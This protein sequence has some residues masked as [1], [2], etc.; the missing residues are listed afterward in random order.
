LATA[1]RRNL[2]VVVPVTLLGIGGL[3][4]TY[5]FSGSLERALLFTLDLME[6]ETLSC[7]L[8]GLL[9]VLTGGVLPYLTETFESRL[10]AV[11]GV[12][13]Y[14]FIIQVSPAAILMVGL[15][16]AGLS[17]LAA[18]LEYG[19][20]APFR[21]GLVSDSAPSTV[22]QA[23]VNARETIRSQWGVDVK[24]S[25]LTVSSTSSDLLEYLEGTTREPYDIVV[26]DHSQLGHL[27][28]EPRLRD[29]L[30]P[31]TIYISLTP[32]S[33]RQLQSHRFIVSAYPDTFTQ[34]SELN[35]FMRRNG[36]ERAQIVVS[37]T[38]FGAAF[39]ALAPRIVVAAS[40]GRRQA[41]AVRETAVTRDRSCVQ[42][43]VAQCPGV[44]ALLD[45]YVDPG[46]VELLVQT[47][48]IPVLIDHRLNA[49]MLDRRNPSPEEAG[50]VHEVPSPDMAAVVIAFALAHAANDRPIRVERSLF[51]GGDDLIQTAFARIRDDGAL[52]YLN[53]DGD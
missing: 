37:D 19:R 43:D 35:H 13:I 52:I 3:V 47:S 26:I 45:P 51:S 27:I 25:P 39:E 34:I 38:S 42:S 46:V 41:T 1:Q 36:I 15:F 16:I 18:L 8:G 32:L 29:V 10:G 30:S 48:D 31:Y 50:N 4:F 40:G 49:T 20:P 23:L 9:L 24:L 33:R 6:N 12:K 17:A 11:K 22:N 53:V 5:F 2:L 7:F 14:R 28:D 44:I 21:I